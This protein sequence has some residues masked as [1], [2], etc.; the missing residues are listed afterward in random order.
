MDLDMEM[1]WRWALGVVTGG[2]PVPNVVH[3]NS[4]RDN[5]AASTR[6]A[7]DVRYFTKKRSTIIAA[8]PAVRLFF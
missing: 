7:N 8:N 1:H 3:P 2:I 4:V 6:P 5:L